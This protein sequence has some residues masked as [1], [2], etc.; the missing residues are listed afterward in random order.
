MRLA[1]TQNIQFYACVRNTQKD[2]LEQQ[3]RINR[4]AKKRAIFERFSENALFARLSYFSICFCFSSGVC[5]SWRSEATST[6]HGCNFYA[7]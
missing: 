3:T 4:Q 5:L 2:Y 7:N 1:H 6:R